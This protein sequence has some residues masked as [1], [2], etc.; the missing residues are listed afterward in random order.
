MRVCFGAFSVD[1]HC[2]ARWSIERIG[3]SVEIQM[4]GEWNAIPH[5]PN[6]PI[7]PAFNRDSFMKQEHRELNEAYE[8]RSRIIASVMDR[9]FV[10]SV[11]MAPIALAATLLTPF[12]ESHFVTSSMAAHMACWLCR[13]SVRASAMAMLASELSGMG[14]ILE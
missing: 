12:S 5:S 3:L 9:A 4:E 6:N 13:S 10:S 7:F 1:R 2:G 8:W 11:S 14:I